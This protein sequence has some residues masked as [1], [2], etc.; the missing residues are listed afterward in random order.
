MDKEIHSN[1]NSFGDNLIQ[2]NNSDKDV[3]NNLF[4]KFRQDVL[5]DDTT[6]DVFHFPTIQLCKDTPNSYEAWY[7]SAYCWAV[8]TLWLLLMLTLV[9]YQIKSLTKFWKKPKRDEQQA[10]RTNNGIELRDA[11]KFSGLLP[12]RPNSEDRNTA[13]PIII[14]SK[15]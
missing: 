13:I 4:F 11:E 10:D 9:H 3:N 7:E 1:N 15:S 6:N 14:N 12:K 5:K 2:F 8:L